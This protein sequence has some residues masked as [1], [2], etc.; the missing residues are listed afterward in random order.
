[1]TI[2]SPSARISC[3]LVSV[4]GLRTGGSEAWGRGGVDMSVP[5]WVGAG[6]AGRRLGWDV[7]EEVV[8]E[9]GGAD[10]RRH[11]HEYPPAG[12]FHRFE[13]IRIDERDVLGRHVAR[14]HGGAGAL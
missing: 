14:A 12:G 13:G 1:M 6:S 11:R 9:A 2:G 5:F 7:D 10:A 8:D 3:S 4:T